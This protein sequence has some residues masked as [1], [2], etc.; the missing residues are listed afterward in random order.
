MAKKDNIKKRLKDWRRSAWETIFF[1]YQTIDE[2]A[3]EFNF[4]RL[5]KNEKRLLSNAAQFFE[6]DYKKGSHR[7]LL[8][9]ILADI[10]FGSRKAGRRRTKQW[11]RKR[12][13]DLAAHWREVERVNPGISDAQAAKAIKHRH[14]GSYQSDEAVRVHLPK[15]RQAFE[16]TKIV[17][18]NEV[19]AVW[20]KYGAD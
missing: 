12:L 16:K 17:P 6:L 15:A 10:V 4:R 3:S 11:D 9:F 13:L 8:L 7:D 2:W 14:P 20:L 19:E 1:S 18:R 5:S